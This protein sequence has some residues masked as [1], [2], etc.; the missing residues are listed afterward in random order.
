MNT[1]QINNIM[2]TDKYT[3][4]IYL[5]TKSLDKLPKIRKY[6]SCLIVNNQSSKRP[7]EHWVA[8]YYDKNKYGEFFDSFGMNPTFYKLNSYLKS[9]SSKFRFNT[10]VLQTQ[11]S[12]Y[13]GFY[14]ILFLLFKA[15]GYSLEKFIS[16][17]KNPYK[18]DKLLNEL[19]EKYL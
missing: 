4:S 8:I 18:N 6:P 1:V 2:H 9:S 15:R 11:S 13:C 14:C 5:G 12:S 19:I 7:G 3:K 17:F 16:L 10:K